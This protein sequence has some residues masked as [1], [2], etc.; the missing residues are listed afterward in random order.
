MANQAETPD[1]NPTD[2]EETHAVHVARVPLKAWQRAKGN[3]VASNMPFRDY[4]IRLLEQC[5][6]LATTN[7]TRAKSGSINPSCDNDGG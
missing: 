1:P 2:K 3:A 5:E 6:P 4:V 7:G